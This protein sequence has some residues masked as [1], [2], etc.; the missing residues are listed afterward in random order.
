MSFTAHRV[1][2]GL[3]SAVRNLSGHV[4][5]TCDGADVHNGTLALLQVRDCSLRSMSTANLQVMTILSVQP[6]SSMHQHWQAL[7]D[8]VMLIR[9]CSALLHVVIL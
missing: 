1:L 4:D 5:L 6:G 2:H 3:C 9:Y 7:T 8:I